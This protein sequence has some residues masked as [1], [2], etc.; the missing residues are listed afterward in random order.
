MNVINCAEFLV[1]R[2]RGIRG[3]NVVGGGLKFAHSHRS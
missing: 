1:D 2:S 3:I